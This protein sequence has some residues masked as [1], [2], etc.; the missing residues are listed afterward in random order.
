MVLIILYKFAIERTEIV[1]KIT[2]NTQVEVDDIEKV[3]TQ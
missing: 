2:S 1:L 3:V